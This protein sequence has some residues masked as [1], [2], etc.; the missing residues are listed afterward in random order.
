[1]KHIQTFE[2]DYNNIKID[3]KKYLVA[4][5]YDKV[6]K[7]FENIQDDDDFVKLKI[8][9]SWEAINDPLLTKNLALPP[10]REIIVRKNKL[11]INW[12]DDVKYQT[13]MIRDALKMSKVL[14]NSLKYNL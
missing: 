13:N 14:A 4:T 6:I 5:F 10:Y 9:Y 11:N 8:I 3:I 7:I 1:M 12:F 2:N